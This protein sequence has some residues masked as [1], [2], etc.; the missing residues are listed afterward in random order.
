[1]SEIKVKNELVENY[2]EYYNDEISEWRELGAIDK[3]QNIFA[4]S[5][6]IKHDKILEIGCG[7]GSILNSL[8]KNSFGKELFGL[9]ISE[10]GVERTRKRNIAGLVECKLFNGYQVP[11]SDKEFDLVI[12]SHVIEHV[13]HPRMILTEALRVGNFVFV[14]VPMEH[15]IWLKKDFVFD[16]VGH[17]NFYTPKTIRNLIQSCEAQVINQI[18]VTPSIKVHKYSSGTSGI[19]KYFLKKISYFIFPKIATSAFTFYTSLLCSSNKIK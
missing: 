17:I 12:L 3:V 7:D 10:S 8:S 18:V 19:I 11:Y 13:E 6:K 15:T 9:E 14:E 2:K 1:M 4:L 5:E 16:H